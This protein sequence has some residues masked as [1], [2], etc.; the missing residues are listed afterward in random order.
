MCLIYS[1]F[2]KK[3]L[4]QH[5]RYF[6]SICKNG[7][8]TILAGGRLFAFTCNHPS[9]R[10]HPTVP[11]SLEKDGGGRS[12][13]QR[14]ISVENSRSSPPATGQAIAWVN[15]FGLRYELN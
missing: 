7:G 12:T 9:C 4:L 8:S 2:L 5:A 1:R 11:L 15:H 3:I 10:H 14:C 13:V 6:S